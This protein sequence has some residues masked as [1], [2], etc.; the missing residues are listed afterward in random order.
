MSSYVLKLVRE[1]SD[2]LIF[3]VTGKQGR[4][5]VWCYAQ[6]ATRMQAAFRQALKQP[7]MM[8]SD[9][10]QVLIS[11]QGDAPPQEIS[12]LVAAHYQ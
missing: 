2:Q 8:I 5:P 3:L 11:G 4:L 12:E 6:V 1:E 9:Y 7:R 10:A